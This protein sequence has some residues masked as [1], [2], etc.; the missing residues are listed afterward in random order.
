MSRIQSILD[1]AEREGVA[2]RHERRVRLP[3]RT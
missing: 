3:H 1:K 2:L